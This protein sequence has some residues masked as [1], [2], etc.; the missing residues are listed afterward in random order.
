MTDTKPALNEQYWAGEPYQD[1]LDI[2]SL[3]IAN[4]ESI[5]TLTGKSGVGKSAMC[6]EVCATLRATS[7]NVIY[8]AKPPVDNT[9]LQQDFRQRYPELKQF[10]FMTAL[11]KLLNTSYDSNQK[12]VLIIDDAHLLSS[13]VITTIRI[14]NN[15]QNSTQRLLQ[16]V[17]SGQPSLFSAL[18]QPQCVGFSQRITHRI[19]LETMSKAQLGCLTVNCYSLQLNNTALDLLYKLTHGKPG[20][21]NQ[22]V[23]LL[24]EQEITEPVSYSQL[25][26]V[27]QQHPTYKHLLYRHRFNQMAA[28]AASVLLISVIFWGMGMTSNEIPKVA[29]SYKSVS[30]PAISLASVST[31]DSAEQLTI[32]KTDKKTKQALKTI[33]KTSP[34]TTPKTSPHTTPK[35]SPKALPKK[36]Q[37]K[38]KVV[39]NKTELVRSIPTPKMNVLTAQTAVTVVTTPKAQ[40]AQEDISNAIQHWVLAWQS[41]D[42]SAY[43]ASYVPNISPDSRFDYR[44][45][46]RNRMLRILEPKWIKLN[47]DSMQIN[48]QQADHISMNIWLSYHSQSYSDKTLK[49]LDW[50]KQNGRWLISYEHNLQVVNP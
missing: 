17:L 2:I 23:Q 30:I 43:L 34:Q 31:I 49:R 36:T 3:A 35:T 37:D 19:N 25:K 5:I 18:D 15:L 33:S 50:I 4:K 9:Q 7:N 32:N 6:R 24:D 8:F 14:M 16:I 27:L 48:S 42:T 47:I 38:L 13:E 39:N 41:Q 20:P 29:A 11:E 26:Q 22:I 12:T 46:H 44:R 28:V 45:W 10:A 1:K 40:V 21:V